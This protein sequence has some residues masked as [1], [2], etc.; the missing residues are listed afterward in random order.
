MRGTR[1]LTRDR[2]IKSTNS[3]LATVPTINRFGQR[4]EALMPRD[5]RGFVAARHKPN[6]IYFGNHLETLK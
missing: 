4:C 3:P 2:L 6:A 5:L 1:T